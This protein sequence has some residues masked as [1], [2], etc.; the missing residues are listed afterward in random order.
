M[1]MESCNLWSRVPEMSADAAAA[2]HPARGRAPCTRRLAQRAVTQFVLP[3]LI[4]VPAGACSVDPEQ[5]RLRAT[6]K[7]TYDKETGRLRELTYDANKNGVIDSWTHMDG[8]KILSTEIDKDE[9]GRIDRWEYY[10][11][12][13]AL[14]RVAI[15]RANNGAP[16]LSMYPGPDGAIARAEI[17]TDARGTIDRWEWY[18]RGALAR[19]EEDT[20]GDGRADK[21][22]TYENGRVVT[23]ALDENGDGRPDRRLTYGATG[24]LVTIESDPDAGG[25][26]RKKVQ[27]TK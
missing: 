14:E 20:S 22:E 21:W 11:A 27:I 26:F 1:I 9:N 23:A 5:Q 15:S 2:G 4:L 6:T 13:G 8:T 12:G 7:A 3:V 19:S 24:A 17:A 10:G 16:D 18:D 25:S